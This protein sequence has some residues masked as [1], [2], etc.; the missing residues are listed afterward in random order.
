MDFSEMLARIKKYM[1]TE[2]AYEAHD[3]PT[4]LMI[5]GE[6]PLAKRPQLMKE[7]L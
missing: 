1:C 4:N 7:D 3:L 6:K 2:A 5:K